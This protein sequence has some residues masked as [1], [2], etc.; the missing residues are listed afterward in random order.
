MLQ[1]SILRLYGVA[2]TPRPQTGQWKVIVQCHHSLRIVEALDVLIRLG[3]V[4]RAINVLQH[5]HVPANKEYILDERLFNFFL[6]HD[7]W[8]LRENSD[9]GDPW[10]AD[11]G[12]STPCEKICQATGLNPRECTGWKVIGGTIN[13]ELIPRSKMSRN[14]PWRI[15]SRFFG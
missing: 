6:V 5:V 8:S 14:C 1:L 10:W 9:R 7:P 2:G 13:E 11:R 12:Q 4:L 3:E 15:Y